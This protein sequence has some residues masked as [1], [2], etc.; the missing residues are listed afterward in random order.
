[1]ILMKTVILINKKEHIKK[2]SKEID[3]NSLVIGLIKKYFLKY[4]LGL[5]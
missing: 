4:K 5:L 1:M 3:Q 2:L